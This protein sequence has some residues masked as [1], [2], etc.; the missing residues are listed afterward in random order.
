M[1]R[2]LFPKDSRKLA[3]DEKENSISRALGEDSGTSTMIFQVRSEIF[4]WPSEMLLLLTVPQ[5]HR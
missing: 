3:D 4:P 1:V 2:D 5:K